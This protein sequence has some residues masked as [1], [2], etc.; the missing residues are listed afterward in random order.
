MLGFPVNVVI[1]SITYLEW[2]WSSLNCEDTYKVSGSR[3]LRRQF[4]DHL[5]YNW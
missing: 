3:D 5:T 4:F 2:Y 1:W